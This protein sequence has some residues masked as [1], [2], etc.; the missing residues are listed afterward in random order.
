MEL[1]LYKG[2][3]LLGLFDSYQEVADLLNVKLDSAKFLA[4]S[5]NFKRIDKGGR[6]KLYNYSTHDHKYYEELERLRG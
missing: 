1:A 6:L 5:S 3:I 4:Y 2:D